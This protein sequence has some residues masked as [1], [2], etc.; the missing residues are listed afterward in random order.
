VTEMDL[1]ARFRA[2]VP[3]RVSPKAER[4][5]HTALHTALH[6]ER[7]FPS[8]PAY[9]ASPH[10]R[11]PLS[12]VA[13]AAGLA[14]AAAAA[15]I[16]AVPHSPTGRPS[17]GRPTASAAVPA[18]ALPTVQELAYR[19]SAAAL[20]AKPVSPGQWVY[21]KSTVTT[22]APKGGHGKSATTQTWQT[23][24]GLRSAWYYRGQLDVEATPAEGKDIGYAELTKLP[25]SPQALVRYIYGR[26][27]QILGPEPANLTWQMT[28]NEIAGLFNHFVLPPRVAAALF[29]ALPYIPGVRAVRQAGS[30]AFIRSEGNLDAEKV[31]LSPSTY[32]VTGTVLADPADGVIKQFTFIARIP[33][34]GPGVRP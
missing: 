4:R 20:A 22:I 9:P 1:L 12:R 3:A 2:E 31:I 17:A 34:S 32:T 11:L 21:E 7:T 19:A 8:L 6:S 5:F 33:V 28:F 10:R 25:P 26:E 24:D 30:V 27:R 14:A 16:V 13:L 15:V 29:R 18:A 23:A